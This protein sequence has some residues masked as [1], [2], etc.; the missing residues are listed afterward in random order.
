MLL[1]IDIGNTNI[2]LGLFKEEQLLKT[3]RLSSRI[4]RTSDEYAVEIAS[5]FLLDNISIKDIEGIIISSVVPPL[6]PIIEKTCDKLFNRKPIFTNLTMKFPIKFEIENLNEIGMDRVVGSSMGYFI[7]KSGTIVVDFGTATTF[8]VIRKDG[9]FIG[10]AIAP[11]I[12]ISLE[13]LISRT[14]KLPKVELSIPPSPIGK[15]T[16]NAIK[17]GMLYGWSGIVERLISE[18]E[19]YLNEKMKLIITGGASHFILPLIKVE[20]IYERDLILKGLKLIYDL[21]K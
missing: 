6:D 11:G 18:V 15:N 12:L 3:Y 2:V 8:D 9:T 21:N 1:T 14:A 4:L 17:S 10:G 7:T 16:V 19:A 13:S 5:L 20:Y